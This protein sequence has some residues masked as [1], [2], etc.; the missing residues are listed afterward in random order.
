MKSSPEITDYYPQSMLRDHAPDMIV[1]A[2]FQA[3]LKDYQF[4]S[5]LRQRGVY[6]ITAGKTI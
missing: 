1:S 6:V 2:L 4:Y 3:R 5:I